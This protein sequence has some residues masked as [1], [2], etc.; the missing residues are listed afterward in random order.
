M[1]VL[2]A[3]LSLYALSTVS[4]FFV[5]FILFLDSANPHYLGEKEE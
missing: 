4:A 1:T 3:H 2:L 5:Y